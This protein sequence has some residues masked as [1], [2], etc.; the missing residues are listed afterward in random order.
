MAYSVQYILHYG[1]CYSGISGFLRGQRLL[2][3]TFGITFIRCCSISLRVYSLR[4]SRFDRGRLES[5]FEDWGL[6]LGLRV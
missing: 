6:G 4:G 3:L 2:R 5:E 1:I